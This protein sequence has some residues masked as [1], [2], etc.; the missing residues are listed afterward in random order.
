M[1]TNHIAA[2]ALLALMLIVPAAI[3]VNTTPAP[4]QT[5]T[6]KLSIQR[7]D[8]YDQGSWD[9]YISIAPYGPEP[10][11][12]P[13]LNMN[14]IGDI[15]LPAGQYYVVLPKGYGSG[16]DMDSWKPEAFDI[17]IAA[18]QTSYVAFIGPGL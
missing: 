4:V 17:T 3:A 9:R 14:G 8:N 15:A 13:Y 11:I 7:L 18:G 1:K 12:H 10:V 16:F 2:L 5:G 6:L